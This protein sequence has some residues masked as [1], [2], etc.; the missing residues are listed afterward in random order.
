MAAPGMHVFCHARLYACM[1]SRRPISVPLKKEGKS[2]TF[3]TV[4][5][6]L[7]VSTLK[8]LTDAIVDEILNN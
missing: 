1:C 3:G 5:I 8:V 4:N 7:S 2:G 6:E